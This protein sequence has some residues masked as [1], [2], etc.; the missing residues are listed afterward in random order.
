MRSMIASL[1]Q[2]IDNV[3]D[4]DKKISQIDKKE[5]GNKFIDNMRSRTDSLLRSTDKV[6]DI[7]NKILEIDKKE[8]EK[9]LLLELNKKFPYTY[10][11]CNGDH[12]KFALLLRKGVYPYEYMDSWEKLDETSILDKEAFYSELNKE[13]ITD[14]DYAHYKK[15]I[16]EFELKDRGEYHD[17]YLHYYL[18]MYSKTLEIN[19]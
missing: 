6:L 19:A 12:N 17:L 4:I 16:K 14:E 2:S 10:K 9:K 8:Q 1:L 3:S 15:V 18:Q 5:I 11:F 13:G 7:A